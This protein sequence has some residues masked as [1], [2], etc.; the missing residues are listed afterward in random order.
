MSVIGTGSLSLRKSDTLQSKKGAIGFTQLVAAHQASAGDTG[1]N[2]NNLTAPPDMVAVG[3]VQPPLEQ[4]SSAKML[5]NRKNLKLISSEKGE[6]IDFLSY[7]VTTNNQ[8][9]FNSWTA[10]DGEIFTIIINNAPVTGM[11]TVD[12]SPLNATG[13]LTAGQADFAVGVPYEV[14]KYPNYQVGAVLVF[15]DG[16]LQFRNVGNA[17][18]SPSADGN[19]EEVNPGG[20]LGVII[21][22]NQAF[23]GDVPVTVISNGLLVHQPI[24]SQMAVL[25]KLSGTVDSLVATT[26]VLAGVPETNFQANPSNVDLKAFGDR[27]LGLEEPGVPG[28]PRLA[29]AVVSGAVTNQSQSGGEGNLGTILNWASPGAKKYVW[30]RVGKTV[31]FSWYIATGGGSAS[32]NTSVFMFDLPAGVPLPYEFSNQPDVVSAFVT[33]GG[34]FISDSNSTGS[35]A[36]VDAQAA[37]GYNGSVLKVYTRCAASAKNVWCGSITYIAAS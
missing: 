28:E 9:V 10:S 11:R 37:L 30:A 33:A 12:A 21:R 26:A 15:V 32:T 2:L 23:P 13:T 5:F 6:L 36:A 16:R 27:M 3:F 19:Y 18:A 31:T 14:G 34:G 8:I 22:F 35:N 4:I 24:D 29:T 7:F 20:G 17:T 25:E 1:F